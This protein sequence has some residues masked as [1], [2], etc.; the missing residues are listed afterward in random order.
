MKSF[1]QNL[2]MALAF[3][4]CGLCAWQWHF[5]TV[6]RG[7]L[8]DKNMEI[9]RRDAAIQGYTNS[10]DKMNQQITRMDQAI[11]GLNDDLKQSLKTNSE[12]IIL[13]KR[14][15]ARLGAS[16]DTL[17]SEIS[18]Y[19]NAVA[20][21]QSNLDAA[22]DGIKT[23]NT[24]LELLAADRDKWVGMYTNMAITNN[25]IISQYNDLVGKYTNVVDRLNKLQPASTNRPGR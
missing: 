25:H 18:Q 24:N 19:T 6:Q 16:N 17:L 14:E 23:Q 10:V 9:N 7:R 11:A 21:L 12:F 5:Q 1:Q 3:A 20:T 8:A 4:L 2:L 22:Y 15:I 13:Q